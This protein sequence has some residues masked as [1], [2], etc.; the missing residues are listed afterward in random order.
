SP[1]NTPTLTPSATATAEVVITSFTPTAV[2]QYDT[3]TLITMAGQGF[4]AQGPNSRVMVNGVAATVE[5]WADTQITFHIGL[6]TPPGSLVVV[7]RNDFGQGSSTLFTVGP[8]VHP[9]VFNYTPST[10]CQ[11]DLVTP[12]TM[13]GL[14]FG[15]I[16]GTVVL[17][18]VYTATISSW[19]D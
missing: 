2:E 19:T 5:T 18:G 3:V 7:Q 6:N 11:G 8:R 16:T 12:I 10:V 17:A 1:T 4:G 13:N 14:R 15:V 9:Y